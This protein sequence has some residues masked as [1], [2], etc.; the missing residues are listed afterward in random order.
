MTRPSINQLRGVGDFAQMIRWN[1]SFP[2]LPS[3]V[4]VGSPAAELNLRCESADVPKMTNQKIET[5]I[6]GHK[7]FDAGISNYTNTITLTFV[8]TVDNMIHEFI[9][10]WRELLWE[11]N[12]GVTVPKTSY[13]AVCMLTRLNN[14]DNPTWY[15]EMI[16]CFPEDYEA[17][18]TLDGV[19][20]DFIKP[21]LTLSYDYFKDAA[22]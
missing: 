9:R 12:T 15:Y 21:T 1:L 18:G 10:S 6:R 2:T 8:E 17:G 13:Q 5:N 11:T 4:S 3:G 20:S 22:L 16:G 14:Q 7:V 19:T